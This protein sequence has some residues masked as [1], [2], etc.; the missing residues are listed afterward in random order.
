[1]GKGYREFLT[2]TAPLRIDKKWSKTLPWRVHGDNLA[3]Q[4]QSD[5][6]RGGLCVCVASYMFPWTANTFSGNFWP[7]FQW[8]VL[9]VSSPCVLHWKV[10][11]NCP[12][13]QP[14][15]VHGDY[16]AGIGQQVVPWNLYGDCLAG[17]GQKRSRILPWDLRGDYRPGNRRIWYRE[18]FTVTESL[19]MSTKMVLTSS[20]DSSRWLPRWKVDK[21]ILPWNVHGERVP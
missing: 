15:S 2:V 21:I 7:I 13:N 17:N 14:G 18:I 6:Q 3:G 12:K 8:D 5:L 1:M 9:G 11:R 4:L 10:G 19:E 16:L 20:V